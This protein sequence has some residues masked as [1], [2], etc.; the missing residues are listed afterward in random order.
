MTGLDAGVLLALFEADGSPRKRIAEDLVRRSGPGG[1]YLDALTL[2][3][4]VRA[5]E[6]GFGLGHAAAASYLERILHAPEFTMACREQAIR[7]AERYRAGEGR[8]KDCLLAEL[9]AAAG[10]E[11]TVSFD[12]DA[13]E[14]A[15]FTLLRG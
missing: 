10:C 5:L 3:E 12:A 6:E 13:A 15:G 4:T 1:C 14:S 2:A 7:A 11:T 8:F 9:H